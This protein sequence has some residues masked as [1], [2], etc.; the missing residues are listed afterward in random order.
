MIGTHH[1]QC[2]RDLGSGE[3]LTKVATMCVSARKETREKV[4]IAMTHKLEKRGL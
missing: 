3:R 2:S 1:E 4:N